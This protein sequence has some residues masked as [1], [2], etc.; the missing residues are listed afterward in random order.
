MLCGLLLCGPVQARKLAFPLLGMEAALPD[1]YKVEQAGA[2]RVNL[3]RNNSPVRVSLYRVEFGNLENLTGDHE[4][5]LLRHLH[6]RLGPGATVQ[7]APLNLGGRKGRKVVM[8][9]RRSGVPWGISAAWV[10]RGGQ[11]GVVEVIYPASQRNE[12]QELFNSLCHSLVWMTPE[13]G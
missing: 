9:G 8:T 3:S 7:L 13:R 12:G 4:V 1:V 5:Q 11:A 10:L 2:N 6:R